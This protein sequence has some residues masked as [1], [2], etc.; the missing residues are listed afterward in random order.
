[1]ARMMGQT[2]QEGSL[3]EKTTTVG[4]VRRAAQV[5]GLSKE[6]E[7]QSVYDPEPWSL[8]R[9]GPVPCLPLPDYGHGQVTASQAESGLFSPQALP[10]PLSL[11][12]CSFLSQLSD[13]HSLDKL[14]NLWDPIKNEKAEPPFQKVLRLSRQQCKAFSEMWGPL[15]QGVQGDCTSYMPLKLTQSPDLSDHPNPVIWPCRISSTVPC[16]LII[17]LLLML[18]RPLYRALLSH[19]LS[20]L[21]SGW[22]TEWD[23]I[24]GASNSSIWFPLILWL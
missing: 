23:E 8:T 16:T 20:F 17:S 7:E 3:E 4:I 21:C 2:I 13:L 12:K 19:G 14:Y 22:N 5:S 18:L 1:M 10:V 6:I 24:Q 11:L 15:R 9:P